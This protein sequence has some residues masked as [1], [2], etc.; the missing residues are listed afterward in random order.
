[1]AL[2]FQKTVCMGT[3]WWKDPGVWCPKVLAGFATPKLCHLAQMSTNFHFFIGLSV[4]A[5]T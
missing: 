1:M 5:P 2:D 4:L 3:G